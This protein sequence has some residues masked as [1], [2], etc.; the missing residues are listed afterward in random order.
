VRR[1]SPGQR[2]AR[3]GGG[4]QYPRP[5]L[6]KAAGSASRLQVTAT[7][8]MTLA[9]V[10]NHS[11]RAAGG[12][13]GSEVVRQGR[14]SMRREGMSMGASMGCRS[15]RHGP[16]GAAAGRRCWLR[17]RGGRRAG[18][19]SGPQFAPKQGAT[20][21]SPGLASRPRRSLAHRA[22]ARPAGGG[23]RAGREPQ[24]ARR[25]SAA[26]SRSSRAFTKTDEQLLAAG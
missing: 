24:L 15:S 19:W 20:S 1:R 8:H 16:L 5:Y 10:A 7:A 23:C 14:S 13:T 2:Q 4:G 18:G 25:R 22:G 21:L 11:G 17:E 3:P 9:T 6:L 12:G 26:S